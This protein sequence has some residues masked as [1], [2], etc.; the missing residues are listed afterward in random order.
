MFAR[1]RGKTLTL[2]GFLL[3][4]LLW[5]AGSLRADLFS[6]TTNVLPPLDLQALQFALLAMAAALVAVL[7]KADWPRSRQIAQCLLAGLGLFVVPALL[8]H[9]SRGWISE[10]SRV[11]LFSLVP[12]FAVVFEPY[13]GRS[14]ETPSEKRLMAALVA[15]VGTLCVFPVDV[16]GSIATGGAFCA[17]IVAAACVAAA[18][19]G[20]VFI[21]T[22]LRGRSLAP[23]V[24]IMC[25]VAAVSFALA[26]T[27]T[28]NA[29]WSWHAFRTELAWSAAVEWPAL[30]L[31]FWL[32]RRMSAVRMTTRFLLAPLIANLIGLLLL[33]PTVNLRAALGLLLITSGTGWLLFKRESEEERDDDIPPA[34]HLT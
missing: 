10:L 29:I 9:F 25:G 7:R 1:K 2:G 6:L 20:A 23:M 28:G 19:L 27:V 30:L 13:I 21:A 3:L 22:D 24:A 15:V 11:A 32:M 16:P 33:R 31:L 17:V 8:V 5:A 12:V 26:S 4:C 34:L 18:N 14:S